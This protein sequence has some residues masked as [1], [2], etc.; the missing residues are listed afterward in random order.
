[1]ILFTLCMVDVDHFKHYNDNH[2]HQAG[3]VALFTLAK[4]VGENI[5]P[6]DFVARYG[7]EEFAVILPSTRVEDA[8]IVA[9]RLCDAVKKATIKMPDGPVLPSITISMGI[10]QMCPGYSLTHLIEAAD[11]Q[12]YKAKQNGRDGFC[13]DPS[14]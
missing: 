8:G 12:L 11:K 1:M 3:D 10:A 14:Q 4:V 5:R 2:G 13:T 6:T 7:G 9:T